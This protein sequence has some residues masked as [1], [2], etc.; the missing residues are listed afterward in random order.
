MSCLEHLD[1]TELPF[2]Q[3]VLNLHKITMI[4]LLKGKILLAVTLFPYH[5]V[6]CFGEKKKRDKLNGKRFLIKNYFFKQKKRAKKNNISRWGETNEKV[7]VMVMGSGGKKMMIQ[8]LKKRFILLHTPMTK[9]RKTVSVKSLK[10][11]HINEKLR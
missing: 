3:N 11:C 1:G 8:Q 10:C 2:C 5:S 7:S 6:V 9:W 4:V